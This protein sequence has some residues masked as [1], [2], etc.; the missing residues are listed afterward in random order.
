MGVLT[1]Y[2][3][4]KLYDALLRQQ[5]L[6]APATWYLAL[7]TDLRADT[8]GPTEPA[9]NNYSRVSVAASLTNFSGTQ[10]PGSTTVSSGTDGTGETNIQV[11]FPTSSGSWGN[12]QSLWFMDAASGGNGWISINLS[13]PFNVTMANVTVS[14]AAGQ[15]S[16]QFS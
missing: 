13:S 10:A 3:K 8:G 16:F 6:S 11:T 7:S 4:N 12:L 14:F 1:N 5:A 2:A 9:G 15:I